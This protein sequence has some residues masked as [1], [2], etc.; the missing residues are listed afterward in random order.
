MIN[1]FIFDGQS[2][3]DFG[4][5]LCDFSGSGDENA[6]VSVIEYTDIK[7]PL[8]NISHKVA[9]NYPS[10]Y[11][12]TLQVCKNIC[13][14]QKDTILT[15]EDVSTIAKWLCR[16]EYKYFKWV[17]DTDDDEIFYEVY[18]NISKVYLYGECYGLEITLTSNRPFGFT[19]EIRYSKTLSANEQFEINVYSDE[20][21]YIY[22][23]VIVTVLSAG[24]W[25]LTNTLENRTTVI[26]NCVANEMITIQGS[27]L[28]QITSSNSS[29]FLASDFN[30]KY[31]RLYNEYR[32]S[33]NA[34]TSNLPCQIQITYRG[35]RKVG[36]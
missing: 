12:R 10:N 16:K 5:M 3:S 4:Y 1:D 7:S 23:D 28:L 29:H 24:N 32:N 21:G 26:K 25:Q 14:N 22:P 13:E 19:R 31:P 8:S 9:N 6:E 33:V 35:I 15:N 34:F 11:T 2:L 17:D 20:E 27:D 36:L 30:Y 18:C